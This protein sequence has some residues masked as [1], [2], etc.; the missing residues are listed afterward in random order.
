M[1]HPKRRINA[2]YQIVDIE[3]FCMHE[4]L[5]KCTATLLLLLLTG[6]GFQLRGQ[7]TL[8]EAMRITYVQVPSGLGPPGLVSRQLPGALTDSGVTVTRDP[9]AA[10]ATITIVREDD[11]RRIVAA[12]R[13][14]IKRQY[15]LAYSVVYRV[16]LAN[17]QVLIP[18][19]SMSANRTLLFDENR[20]LGF[21]TAQEYLLESMAEDLTWQILRR[22][23]AIAGS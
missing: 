11:G 13:F 2:P 9:R 22:L 3:G 10:T 21:E 12:D 17:G 19:E 8:P 14:D 4:K 1:T 20:V 7:A 6:C 23:Q 15:L 5:A 18:D 16:T